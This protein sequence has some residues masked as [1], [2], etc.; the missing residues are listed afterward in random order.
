MARKNWSVKRAQNK[1][2]HVEKFSQG[3]G[4]TSELFEE[5]IGGSTTKTIT[6]KHLG[7]VKYLPSLGGIPDCLSCVL[8][9]RLL[10]DTR[11]HTHTHIYMGE[12]PTGG[13]ILV[14]NL[15]FS[16]VL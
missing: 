3:P 8:G 13:H 6:I 10:T 2:E 15:N 1:V 9:S 11:K 14:K 12:T 16:P 5:K 4:R 7:W